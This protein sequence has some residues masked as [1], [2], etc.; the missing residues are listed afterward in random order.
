VAGI[1]REVIRKLDPGRHASGCWIRGNAAGRRP[2]C[3]FP[4]AARAAARNCACLLVERPR[5][6][7]VLASSGSGGS[8]EFDALRA[9]RPA[10]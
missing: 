9:S 3:I 2:G 4:V 10:N 5:R 8:V 1:H 7:G 6:R